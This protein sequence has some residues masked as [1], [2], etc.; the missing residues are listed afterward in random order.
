MGKTEEVVIFFG[1]MPKRV[2]GK[3][4]GEGERY[5]VAIG[6]TS[7]DNPLRR[8][9]LDDLPGTKLI[10][11]RVPV[12]IGMLSQP[13][14]GTCLRLILDVPTE[15]GQKGYPL[16]VRQRVVYELSQMDDI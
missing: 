7:P 2:L 1:D 5:L 8:I 16:A 11:G 6:S 14:D 3:S 15:V 9:N 4:E 10:E 12:V 13:G